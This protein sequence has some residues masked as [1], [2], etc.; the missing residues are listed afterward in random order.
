MNVTWLIDGNTD[1]VIIE[2][3][4]SGGFLITFK[5]DWKYKSFIKYNSNILIEW[6]DKIFKIP[7]KKVNNKMFLAKKWKPIEFIMKKL[8]SVIQK[9]FGTNGMMIMIIRG[10]IKSISK[11]MAIKTF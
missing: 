10:I 11:T 4:Y 7:T 5:E 8:N 6:N 2:E 1:D 3:L 9:K